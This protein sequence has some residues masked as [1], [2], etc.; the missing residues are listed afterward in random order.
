MT[1]DNAKTQ[2]PD[3]RGCAVRALEWVFARH[4]SLD[5]FLEKD[6]RFGALPTRDKALSRAIIGSSLR[7][8]GQIDAIIDTFLSRPMPRQAVTARQILRAGAAE[9]LF[10]RSA[11]HGVVN[12]FVQM[13]GNMRGSRPYKGM[14]N[15]LLRRIDREG[16]ELL[17]TLPLEL[18]IPA[19]LAGNWNTVYG[20][21]AAKQAATALKDPP[22][23]DLTILDDVEKWAKDLGGVRIGEQTLR[24]A[25]KGRIED[26]QGY[27]DGKWI[28]QDLAAS[29]PVQILNPQPGE[30]I[31]DF[32]AAPGGKTVQV[33][34]A[35]AKVTAVDNQQARLGR[36]S[37]NLTRTGQQAE[38]ICADARSWKPDR[39]FDAIL[40]DAPC[41]ATGIFRHHPDVLYT[42]REKDVASFTERQ[43][44]L[45]INAS[46]LLKSGGRLIYCVCS[47]QSVEAEGVIAEILDKTDLQLDPIVTDIPDFAKPFQKDGMIRIPPGAL[48]REGGLDAFFVARLR[49]V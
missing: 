28:V 13:A 38:I 31:A 45:A 22:H 25:N 41:S 14:I 17:Q 5:V 47:A 30:E 9:L 37:Q 35:G 15:A 1:N 20:P 48:P 7:Q 27:Q 21:E 40:L 34:A 36:L 8:L 16:D 10:L 33:A 29:I 18:N 19:W 26:I 42:R 46:K 32:C 3:P 49:K 39:L 6:Q 2:Q 43:I 23:L 44:S 12:S 24:L 11:S 4:K